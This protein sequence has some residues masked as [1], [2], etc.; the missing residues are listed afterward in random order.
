MHPF[1]VPSVRSLLCLFVATSLAPFVALFGIDWQASLD[2]LIESTVQRMHI[3]PAT[4]AE[5][6]RHP[7]AGCFVRSSAVGYDGAVLRNLVQM[8]GDFF[9]GDANS[10]R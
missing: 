5:F 3:L 10:V 2:P 6:L 1:F 7:G 4:V 8:F 9:S